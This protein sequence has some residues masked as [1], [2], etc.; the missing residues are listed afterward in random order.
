[1]RSFD[2]D[3]AADAA[4]SVLEAVE[5]AILRQGIREKQVERERQHKEP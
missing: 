3:D 4:L 2:Y 1:M 5:N